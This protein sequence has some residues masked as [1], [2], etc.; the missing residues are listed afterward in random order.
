M[1]RQTG[2]QL[3]PLQFILVSVEDASSPNLTC[4]S[5]TAATRVHIAIAIG[6][7]VRVRA[8]IRARIRIRAAH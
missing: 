7:R 1:K 3:W 5:L 4:K 2:K 8:R 6:I